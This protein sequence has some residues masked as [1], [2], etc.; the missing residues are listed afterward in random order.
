MW[1]ILVIFFVFNKLG[2]YSISFKSRGEVVIE[3]DNHD[4]GKEIRNDI[5]D[6]FAL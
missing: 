2:E 1:L 3:F 6:L 5:K 4:E